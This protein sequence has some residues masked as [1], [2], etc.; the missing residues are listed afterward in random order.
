ML[1]K[2]LYLFF[3]LNS[4]Y[5]LHLLGDSSLQLFASYPLSNCFIDSAQLVF[6]YPSITQYPLSK[7]LK[8]FQR[9]TMSHNIHENTNN[10]AL[11]YVHQSDELAILKSI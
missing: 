9:I 11:F 10:Y 3:I 6:H 2:A 1:V 5:V 7:S 4:L 8:L